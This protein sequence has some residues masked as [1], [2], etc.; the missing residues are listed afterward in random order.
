MFIEKR[1]EILT[2]CNTGQVRE[3]IHTQLLLKNVQGL[4]GLLFLVTWNFMYIFIYKEIVPYIESDRILIKRHRKKI[5]SP[6]F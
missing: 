1:S 6:D 2:V 3:R 5:H 4:H